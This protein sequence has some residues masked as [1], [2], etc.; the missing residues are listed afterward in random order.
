MRP[1]LLIMALL[2]GSCG[3]SPPPQPRV[4]AT[5]ANARHPLALQAEQAF[6]HALQ[7]APQ[8]HEAADRQLQVAFAVDPLDFQTSLLLGISDLWWLAEPSDG[9]DPTLIAR[10][11]LGVH[12]LERALALH[13]DDARIASW[14]VPLKMALAGMERAPERLPSL[15]G[16]FQAAYAKNPDFHAVSLALTLWRNPADS[17]RFAEGRALLTRAE[18][19]CNHE[20]NPDCRNEAHWPHNVQGFVLFRADYA[21]KSGDAAQAETLL[22]GASKSDAYESFPFKEAVDRRLGDLKG[23]S[24]GLR[25]D[26]PATP[27][28]LGTASGIGCQVCHRAQ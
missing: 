13:P 7:Y 21:L 28:V 14:L 22:R 6:F 12:Y 15:M 3:H 18:E 23:W 24:D 17:P 19:S 26:D 5:A 16:E 1:T 25:R 2:L 10:A 9:H 4:V 27:M 8:E 20:M 11:V